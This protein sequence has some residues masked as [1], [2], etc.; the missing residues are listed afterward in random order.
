[1]NKYFLSTLDVNLIKLFDSRA[2]LFNRTTV[3][4]RVYD[5][6]RFPEMFYVE[7]QS[8]YRNDSDSMLLINY[9]LF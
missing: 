1:M 3:I 4:R 9:D 6:Y 2:S 5:A 7:K 8:D